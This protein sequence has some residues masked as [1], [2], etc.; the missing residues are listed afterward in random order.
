METL[1]KTYSTVKK[2]VSPFHKRIIAWI[3]E[4]HKSPMVIDHAMVHLVYDGSDR[5]HG[6]DRIPKL[7]D[8]EFVRELD[9]LLAESFPLYD[10]PA[11]RLLRISDLSYHD[12]AEELRACYSY[13]TMRCWLE[14]V[15]ELPV[16]CLRARYNIPKYK[17][18][19]R[20]IDTVY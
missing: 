4:H 9:R 13:V 3:L 10:F 19:D 11:Q 17:V 14:E 8:N 6:S 12:L 2:G 1:F 5:I 18:V 16:T 20:D 7:L 15:E